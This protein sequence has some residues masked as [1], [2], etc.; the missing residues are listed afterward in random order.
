MMPIVSSLRR[1]ENAD[2]FRLIAYA[3]GWLKYAPIPAEGDA[4]HGLSGPIWVRCGGNV[5]YHRTSGKQ[6]F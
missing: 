5:A 2:Y 1:F 6:G 4:G 3:T